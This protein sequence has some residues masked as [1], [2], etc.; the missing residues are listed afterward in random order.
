MGPFMVM[1]SITLGD[2]T[3]TVP[4]LLKH[5]ISIH[6][7]DDLDLDLEEW[8]IEGNKPPPGRWKPFVAVDVAKKKALYFGTAL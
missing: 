5:T 3:V 6:D 7:N 1:T 4:P 2:F 8:K